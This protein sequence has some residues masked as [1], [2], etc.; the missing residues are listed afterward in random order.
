MAQRGFDYA[1]VFEHMTPEMIE[2]ANIALDIQLK[3]EE[4]AMKRKSKGGG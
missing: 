2:E 3:A 1:T 4:R